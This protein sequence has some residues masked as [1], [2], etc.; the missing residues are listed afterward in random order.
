[1]VLRPARLVA[2]RWGYALGVFSEYLELGMD[3]DALAQERKAQLKR[4]AVLRGGRD[5]LVFAADLKP[6]PAPVQIGY[7]DLLPINDQLANL[8]GGALDLILETPGGSGEA[9]EDIVKAIRA[10]YSDVAVIIPGWAKSAG[11]IMAMAA[12]DILMEPSTSALG[13]IDA[14]MNSGGKVF[15]A[16]AL[17][18]GFDK[19]KAEVAASGVLNKAFIPILQALSVGELESARNAWDFAKTLVTDWLATYK[20]KDWTTH[21]TTGQ[22][23]T[24]ADK[25]ARAEE[26]AERLRDH[27]HWKTH[28]RSIKLADLN[29]MRLRIND[30]SGDADLSDAIRR[31]HT[32][33]QMTFDSG[34]YKLFETPQSQIY[35]FLGPPV[36]APAQQH[37]MGGAGIAEVDLDC[38]KCKRKSK[39][40]ANLGSAQPLKPGNLP[41]PANNQFKCPG[42]GAVANLTAIRRTIEM[43]A[44]QPV[45]G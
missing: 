25:I 7:D 42:C 30:Y 45:V 2:N 23:V 17:I 31:Y 4:I 32:L 41:F 33:M 22:P 16:H 35:R 28:G 29:A 20:F 12:D 13:P 10:K 37:G 34:C 19:I 44:K 8:H 24:A 6:S 1:M 11:T 15:S 40:Q 43:Q 9:A 38:A 39:V 14:Q 5:I 3:F 36:G 26:I 27:G 18:T 21:S